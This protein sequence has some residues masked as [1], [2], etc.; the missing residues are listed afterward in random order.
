MISIEI[1]YIINN[2]SAIST[3]ENHTSYIQLPI[4]WQTHAIYSD[5]RAYEHTIVLM[6]SG[7]SEPRERS[8]KHHPSFSIKCGAGFT[9]QHLSTKHAVH[10]RGYHKDR[11]I[12]TS[13]QYIP[14]ALI[15]QSLAYPIR[16]QY[17][18]V[19]SVKSTLTIHSKILYS[20]K[21]FNKY[22]MG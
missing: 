12:R 3:A 20:N 22:M 13:R 11:N 17:Y 18:T 15:S 19:L 21:P 1:D 10:R 2:P 9:R 5:I 14:E 4:Y 6:H 16:I 7:D 8:Q